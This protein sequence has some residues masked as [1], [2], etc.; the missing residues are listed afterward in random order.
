MKLLK[1]L[2]VVLLFS[3]NDDS[4]ETPETGVP[5]Q[6]V[7]TMM[8]PNAT[9]I[10]NVAGTYNLEKNKE[11]CVREDG[12]YKIFLAKDY[13]TDEKE[14]EQEILF[15]SI[16]DV[17]KQEH[18]YFTEKIDVAKRLERDWEYFDKKNIPANTDKKLVCTSRI[19]EE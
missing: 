17:A 9:D 12:K 8:N 18:I 14:K 3:C 5:K 15:Y 6:I 13:Y 10:T 2:F 16:F 7:V 19:K 4:T 1:L 11:Y